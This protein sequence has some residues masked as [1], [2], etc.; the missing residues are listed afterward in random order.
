NM[1][2]GIKTELSRYPGTAASVRYTVFILESGGRLSF[3]VDKIYFEDPGKPNSHSRLQ[4]S[5][6]TEQLI[7]HAQSAEQQRATEASSLFDQVG[8]VEPRLRAWAEVVMARRQ[9]ESG[10]ASALTDLANPLRSRLDG[11]TPTGLPAAFLAA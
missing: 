9:F 11:L 8:K 4:W 1:L 6:A 7:E 5:R 3:P 10:N 2:S